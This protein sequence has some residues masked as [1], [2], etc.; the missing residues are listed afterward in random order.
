VQGDAAA[1]NNMA[2]RLATDG[3]LAWRDPAL[4]HRL[5]KKA[6]EVSG[7][8]DA[9]I[10]DS[11]ARVLFEIGLLDRAI[12][13]QKKAVALDAAADGLKE[14]LAYYEA[15]AALKKEVGTP[16]PAPKSPAPPKKK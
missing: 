13:E 12:E 11:Y 4:A 16:A 9:G 1:L 14:T 8:K 6:V 2:W 7:G 15:C 3:D 5:A 10:V